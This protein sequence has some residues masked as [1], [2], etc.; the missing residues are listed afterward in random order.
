MRTCSI[1]RCEAAPSPLYCSNETTPLAQ[2]PC[3][4]AMCTTSTTRAT[5]STPARTTTRPVATTAAA[6][7]SSSGDWPLKGFECLDIV[8]SFR[9]TGCL[10]T[11][12]SPCGP[13]CPCCRESSVQ[14]SVTSRT[15]SVEPPPADHDTSHLAVAWTAILVVTIVIAS[16]L[17]LGCVYA[18]LRASRKA[19]PPPGHGKPPPFV[20]RAATANHPEPIEP[21]YKVPEAWPSWN[22]EAWKQP[23]E[24]HYGDEPQGGKGVRFD[25]VRIGRTTSGSVPGSPSSATG[26][27][28]SPCFSAPQSP[29]RR[30]RSSAPGSLF[31]DG[32]SAT[33]G[34]GG[35]PSRPPRSQ[36][37]QSVGGSPSKSDL[38]AERRSP[39]R[40]AGRSS[41]GSTPPSSPQGGGGRS[42]ASSPQRPHK[43][44]HA[45]SNSDSPGPR[46]SSKRP[47]EKAETPPSSPRGGGARGTGMPSTPGSSSRPPHTAEAPSPVS[48]PPPVADPALAALVSRIDSEL[49]G[50]KGKDLEWRKQHFKSLMLTWH[51]DKNRSETPERAAAVFKHL[52]DRRARYLEA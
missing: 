39:K 22:D 10:N 17:V 28:A 13:V 43:P 16:V 46:R 27:S 40:S 50:T 44:G 1:Y 12:P 25:P 34:Y 5:S 21:D 30:S 36:D 19:R 11:R 49:D 23:Q 18:V 33:D 41:S 20:R 14:P 52:F 37:G 42:E 29:T 47:S 48:S 3:L 15:T 38:G 51:P 32:S 6:S 2:D 7:T 31:A 8:G 26:A 9:P 45:A 4:F 35:S 24:V